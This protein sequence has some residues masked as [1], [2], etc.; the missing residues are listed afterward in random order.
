LRE[1]SVFVCK[2]SVIPCVRG[3]Y[4]RHPHSLGT[5]S[6]DLRATSHPKKSLLCRFFASVGCFAVE[7]TA[8]SSAR[9]SRNPCVRGRYSL[10]SEA[11][12]PC[13]R[14]R[15]S[16][17]LPP[18]AVRH[19]LPYVQGTLSE[20]SVFPRAL[21]IDNAY[22]TYSLCCPS[23]ATILRDQYPHNHNILGNAPQKAASRNLGGSVWTSPP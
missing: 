20:R 21:R 7:P 6:V 11:G 2:G 12:I 3:R 10:A 18:T 22:V 9:G 23:R 16:V 17:F 1:R 5:S 14:G 4:S 8:T 15:Y 19:F 13:A